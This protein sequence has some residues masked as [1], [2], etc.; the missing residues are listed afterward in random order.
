MELEPHQYGVLRT[1]QKWRRDPPTYRS[2]IWANVKPLALMALYCAA[3]GFACY[4]L[5][6]IAL[7]L[8]LAG[9]WI[10]QLVAECARIRTI[11]VAWSVLARVLD[12]TRVEKAIAN[13]SLD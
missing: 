7:S 12:W 8:M 10:G 2:L 3:A 5:G 6:L 4:L 1:Y 13:R 11:P 9:F